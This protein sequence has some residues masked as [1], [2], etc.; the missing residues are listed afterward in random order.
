MADGRQESGHGCGNCGAMP[1]APIGSR[2][3]G[4]HRVENVWLCGRCGEK[5]ITSFQAAQ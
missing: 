3:V 5:W 1:I 4:Q 2:F